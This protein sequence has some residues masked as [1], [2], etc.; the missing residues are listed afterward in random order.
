MNNNSAYLLIQP[1]DS[2][3]IALRDL[4]AGEEILI[5]DKNIT[6]KTDIS[7]GIKLQ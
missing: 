5:N 4:S 6:L 7:F 2:V 3:C 1:D